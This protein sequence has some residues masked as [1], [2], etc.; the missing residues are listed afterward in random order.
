MAEDQ[1]SG[2]SITSVFAQLRAQLHH[3]Q[4]IIGTLLTFM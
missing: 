3:R 2:A 4:S 1:F